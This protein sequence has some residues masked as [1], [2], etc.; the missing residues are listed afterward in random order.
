MALRDRDD[1]KNICL[2]TVLLS[3]FSL[4]SSRL[5]LLQRL[6]SETDIAGLYAMM[7]TGSINLKTIIKRCITK[8][9]VN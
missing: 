7:K 6:L 8:L 9:A 3:N 1:N 2:P 4:S 5:S